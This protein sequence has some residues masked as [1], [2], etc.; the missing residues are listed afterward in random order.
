[1]NHKYRV[2]DRCLYAV[3]SNEGMS[4]TNLASRDFLEEYGADTMLYI[5]SQGLATHY[6]P[7]AGFRPTTVSAEKIEEV[8]KGDR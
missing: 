8:I 4:L 2:K 7:G 1:M 5:D 6:M 3:D